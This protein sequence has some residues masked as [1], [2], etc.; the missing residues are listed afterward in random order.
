MP[1]IKDHPL[2]YGLANELHARPF[3]ALSVPSTAVYLAIKQEHGAAG[4]DRVRERHDVDTEALKLAALIAATPP[5][6]AP[7]PRRDTVRAGALT[8]D[9][10]H[11]AH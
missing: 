2:R 11:A 6:P 8:A 4:R 10:D 7:K 1:P 3:P 5:R 9:A